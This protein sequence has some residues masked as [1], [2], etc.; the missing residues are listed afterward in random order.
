[1]TTSES[2]GTV[3]PIVIPT[4]PTIIL[5]DA[6]HTV[7]VD[8]WIVTQLDPGD[9]VRVIPNPEPLSH[10]ALNF[11]RRTAPYEA[12]WKFCW[13][14]IALVGEV[15]V[16]DP[17]ELIR[18]SGSDRRTAASCERQRVFRRVTCHA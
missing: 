15:I 9:R 7:T 12:V 5:G 6:E 3:K 10:G 18:E 17:A 1:V 11:P 2:G 8:E 4:K 14:G 16:P 13:Y